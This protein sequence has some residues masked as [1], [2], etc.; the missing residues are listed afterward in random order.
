MYAIESMPH[1]NVGER[2]HASGLAR[3]DSALAEVLQLV[4]HLVKLQ[5]FVSKQK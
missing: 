3:A 1:L 4:L 2:L 5:L